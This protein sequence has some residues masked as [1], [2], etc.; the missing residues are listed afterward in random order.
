MAN[1]PSQTSKCNK[2]ERE[3]KCGEINFEEFC[4]VDFGIYGIPLIAVEI[5]KILTSHSLE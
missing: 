1:V 3:T 4:K 2:E 5:I